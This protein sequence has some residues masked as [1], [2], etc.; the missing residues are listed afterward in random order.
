MM[1]CLHYTEQHTSL[2]KIT[3]LQPV[4]LQRALVPDLK[5]QRPG[6]PA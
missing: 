3:G 2:Q 1:C 6:F 5:D 4:I